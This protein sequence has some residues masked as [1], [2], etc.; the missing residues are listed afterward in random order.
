[1]K[2][3]IVKLLII[4]LFLSVG[5][6][7]QG[8]QQFVN[9]GIVYE[10]SLENDEEILSVVDWDENIV[11]LIVPQGLDVPNEVLS[12]PQRYMPVV[13]FKPILMG[14]DK[15]SIS[16]ITFM[17][18]IQIADNAFSGFLNLKKVD[19]SSDATVIPAGIFK[20]L[21]NIKSF[22]I[23]PNIT[24][25][26]KEAFAGCGI[27]NI[28]IPCSVCK[29]EERA[30]ANCASLAT[31]SMEVNYGHKNLEQMVIN[32]HQFENCTSL[33]K[34]IIGT[35][36]SRINF[37]EA[38]NGCTAIKELEIGESKEHIYIEGYYLNEGALTYS[39]LVTFKLNRDYDSD[40]RE[41]ITNDHNKP[42]PF[43]NHPT[44]E[45]VEI[46]D[47]VTK[48]NMHAFKSCP[49]LHDIK[50]SSSLTEIGN[51]AF[52]NLPSLIN[53]ELPDGIT[54][55]GDHLFED[56]VNLESVKIPVSVVA[57]NYC[58]FKNCRNLQ[59]FSLH[60]GLESIGNCAFEGCSSLTE[61]TIPN[62]VRTCDGYAF[63]GCE[64]LCK[65]TIGTGL[66]A[67]PGWEL[68]KDCP[69]LVDFVFVDGEEYWT[70]MY[71]ANGMGVFSVWPIRNLYLGRNHHY[72]EHYYAEQPFSCSKTL[73]HVVLGD[74]LIEI[75]DYA[76]H[77]C[78][79]VESVGF[80]RNIERIGRYSF[81]GNKALKSVS[82]PASVNNIGDCCFCGCDLLSD[83]TSL[84][85]T[86]PDLNN[87][88]FDGKTYSGAVLHVLAEAYD[89]YKAHPVWGKFFN[90]IGDASSGIDGVDADDN[91]E[92]AVTVYNLNGTKVSDSVRNLPSG[93]YIIRKGDKVKKL[94]ID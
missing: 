35:S 17:G 29:I 44:L 74:K 37:N 12:E 1:M 64:N 9:N 66:E 27:E 24:T 2:G 16:S 88:V 82:L 62:S 80:G 34:V 42:S 89:A 77:L 69:N 39:P 83:V 23:G 18:D 81:Y 28:Y 78:V 79:N 6:Y 58:A 57:I 70:P 20:G 3:S 47:K 38:F 36:V 51:E 73:E 60:E 30:F 92:S 75:Q 46:G 5:A 93:I 84:N 7:T 41:I 90:I 56:C 72:R 63:Q 54:T 86:P 32:N 11:D 33:N 50:F 40:V 8:A 22:N 15:P 76:F 19:L 26:G 13:W 25:I 31:L 68:F 52:R 49:K 85:I 94:F 21:I 65:M 10:I 61:F 59:N 55:I 67:L 45:T 14:A 87:N 4:V 43:A 53:I 71:G 48:L 91:R